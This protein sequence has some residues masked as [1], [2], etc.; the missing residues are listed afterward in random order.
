MEGAPH[1]ETGTLETARLALDS[2][3]PHTETSPPAAPAHAH[4]AA[5]VCVQAARKF[6]ARGRLCQVKP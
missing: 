3:R 2:A 1:T 5:L 6:D 4:R